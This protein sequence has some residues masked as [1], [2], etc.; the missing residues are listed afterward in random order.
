M[1]FKRKIRVVDSQSLNLPGGYGKEERLHPSL[2]MTLLFCLTHNITLI[3]MNFYVL[4]LTL[5]AEFV[6]FPVRYYFPWMS[7]FSHLA[8]TCMILL[9]L[10]QAPNTETSYSPCLLSDQ[11][12]PKNSMYILKLHL[13]FLC[14]KQLPIFVKFLSNVYR[15]FCSIMIQ[16]LSIDISPIHFSTCLM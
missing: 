4:I 1:W 12:V 11:Q 9:Q 6:I 2:F 15:I 7:S 3:L 13:P 14:P 16:K 5:K 10:A 8:A